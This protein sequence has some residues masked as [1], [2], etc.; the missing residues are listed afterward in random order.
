MEMSDLLK[1]F[2]TKYNSEEF[3]FNIVIDEGDLL[4]EKKRKLN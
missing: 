4:P 1:F 3:E 2:Y